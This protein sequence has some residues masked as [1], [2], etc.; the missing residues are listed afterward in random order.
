MKSEQ[1][2]VKRDGGF[3][4]KF[5]SA[6]NGVMEAEGQLT[7]RNEHHKEAKIVREK[8]FQGVTILLFKIFNGA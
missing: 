2:Q 7:V 1:S 5:L 4:N 3:K 8:Q 6:E